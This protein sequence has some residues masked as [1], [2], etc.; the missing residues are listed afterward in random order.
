ME[1]LRMQGYDHQMGR[2]SHFLVERLTT[3]TRGVWRM[4]VHKRQRGSAR[5]G[6]CTLVLSHTRKGASAAAVKSFEQQDQKRGDGLPDGQ[7]LQNHIELDFI[8]NIIIVTHKFVA[9]CM[10]V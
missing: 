10:N 9:L 6:A 1:K 8:F 2:P 3:R 5:E 4:H 7:V